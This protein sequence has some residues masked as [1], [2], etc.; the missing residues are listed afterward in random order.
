MQASAAGSQPIQ[1]AMH[2]HGQL[3]A[4]VQALPASCQQ[5]ASSQGSSPVCLLP[6]LQG[7]QEPS[8]A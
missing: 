8:S 2:H 1:R 5:S 3:N 4:L 7:V 6:C